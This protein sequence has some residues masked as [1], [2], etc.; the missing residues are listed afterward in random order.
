MI[1][2][3]QEAIAVMSVPNDMAHMCDSFMPQ[4]NSVGRGWQRIYYVYFIEQ[5]QSFPETFLDVIRT[6]LFVEYQEFANLK[7]AKAWVE[8]DYEKRLM[9]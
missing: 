9:H 1:S 5:S 4:P 3:M 7:E 6:E 8:S 2:R